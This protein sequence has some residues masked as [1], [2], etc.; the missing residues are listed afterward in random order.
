[1]SVLVSPILV[2]VSFLKRVMKVRLAKEPIVWRTGLA[3][4]L[5]TSLTNNVSFPGSL[6]LPGVDCLYVWEGE[7]S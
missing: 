2:I 1:M 4:D 5:G 7:L 6:K 3:L